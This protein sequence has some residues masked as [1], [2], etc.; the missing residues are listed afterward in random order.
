M[1]SENEMWI[2]SYY[3]YSEI[4]G[5]TFFGALT[6]MFRSGSIGHNLTKH[7]ADE[8]QHAWL[9]T[10]CI[11]DC[12]HEPL[13]IAKTYQD[14]YIEEIGLPVNIM[15]ILAITQIFERRVI[16]QYARHAKLDR[17]DPRIHQT[18]TRILQD[19]KWHIHWVGQALHELAP[20]YG[21]DA[22]DGTLRRY[23]EADARIYARTLAEHEER[24]SHLFTP[25][26]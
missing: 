15:E 19:E 12:G 23:R 17:L 14:Q 7:F 2:L 22:I 25:R 10:Q 1:F 24:L 18:F 13:A 16:H 6:R 26:E 11:H 9:W 8:S 3:R 21:Q 20:Q 4:S 5:A